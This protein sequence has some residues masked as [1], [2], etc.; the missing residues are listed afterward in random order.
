MR[1]CDHCDAT[2]EETDPYLVHLAD[3]HDRELDAEERKRVKNAASESRGLPRKAVFG[4]ILLLTVIV[5]VYVTMFMGPGTE[6]P[7]GL[8]E[9]GDE[10]VIS[11][12]ETEPASSIVHV[13]SSTEIEY[14]TVPPTGGKHYGTTV[15]AGFYSE[16]RPLGALVHS[17]EHGAVVVYY[18]SD[19]LTETAEDDLRAYARSQT[20]HWQSF[21]AVPNPKDDPAS[22]YVL[23][24]WEKRLTMDEYEEETVRAFVAEYIG[25]G[26]E[27]PVRGPAVEK[28]EQSTAPE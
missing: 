7:A 8:P 11:Q 13:N 16:S 3:A 9:H 17:L 5:A 26:P 4:T 2:F 27:N 18:D 25:R 1:E 19:R 14:A 20:S 28:T 15:S 23:T 10:A 22:P 21:I 6:S 24:A 12:V